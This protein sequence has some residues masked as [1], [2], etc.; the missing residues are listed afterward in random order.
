MVSTELVVCP[1][2]TRRLPG[3]KSA[4]QD[5]LIVAVSGKVFMSLIVVEYV[6]YCIFIKALIVVIV[7]IILTHSIIYLIMIIIMKTVLL[8]LLS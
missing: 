1:T 6:I 2:E 4:P 8:F 7:I 3:A 5:S